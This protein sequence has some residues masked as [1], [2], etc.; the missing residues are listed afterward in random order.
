MGLSALERNLIFCQ[1]I[2]SSSPPGKFSLG[3][4]WKRAGW[5]THRNPTTENKQIDLLFPFL[6]ASVAVYQGKARMGGENTQGKKKKVLLNFLI[7]F[8]P[9][10]FH[11]E[12]W[13]ISW[14]SMWLEKNVLSIA[15]ESRKLADYFLKKKKKKK[16]MHMIF[17]SVD[18]HTAN[19]QGE[20]LC[21]EITAETILSNRVL[22]LLN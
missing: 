15:S 11:A 16:N 5:L 7:V 6:P 17:C 9:K 12:F 21:G 2:K 14:N 19:A 18:K 1:D 10:S 20:N 8:V 22:H 4:S 13:F 3:R